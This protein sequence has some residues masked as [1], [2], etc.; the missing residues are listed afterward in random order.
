MEHLT[1]LRDA[2]YHRLLSINKQIRLQRKQSNEISNLVEQRKQT[3]RL[4]SEIKQEIKN[5]N[6]QSYHGLLKK[7]LRP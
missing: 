5:H 6:A 2:T 4:L 1:A 3:D 7:F